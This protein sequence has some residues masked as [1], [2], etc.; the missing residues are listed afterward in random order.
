MPACYAKPDTA[1]A[2]PFPISPHESPIYHKRRRQE[3]A[4]VR[5]VVDVEV[6]AHDGRGECAESNRSGFWWPTTKRPSLLPSPH[7][8]CLG[9]FLRVDGWPA[10][11]ARRDLQPSGHLNWDHPD[12]H[13]AI[14]RIGFAH[15]SRYGSASALDSY[16][17]TKALPAIIAYLASFVLVKYNRISIPIS[18]EASIAS[19]TGQLP[20]LGRDSTVRTRGG[21]IKGP[22]SDPPIGLQSLHQRIPTGFD[23]LITIERVSVRN[24]FKLKLPASQL[25]AAAFNSGPVTAPELEDAH[26]LLLRCNAVCVVLAFVGFLLAVTGIMA[27][28]WSTFSLAPGIFVS[29][30]FIV[31][32]IGA[33]YA[34]R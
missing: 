25:Y 11:R 22:P 4:V 5:A 14:R 7:G 30:C 28:V 24:L 8:F 27:Y 10:S 26:T 1:L 34:L 2:R 3:P 31:S 21:S 13:S 18:E 20:Q 29:V 33:C 17:F 15:L 12:L 32:L 16:S 6:A 23:P 19:P 9:R